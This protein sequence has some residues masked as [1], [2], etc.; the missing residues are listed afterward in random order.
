MFYL[1]YRTWKLLA[2]KQLK[3]R[4]NIVIKSCFNM[5]Q[6]PG[7]LIRTWS[8]DKEVELL[9]NSVAALIR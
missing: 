2:Y 1:R 8:L 5:L 4:A 3:S 6:K 9:A 7:F